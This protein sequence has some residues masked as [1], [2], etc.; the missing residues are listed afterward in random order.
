M[1]WGGGGGEVGIG[2]ERGGVRRGRG[3]GDHPDTAF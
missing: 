2:G 3:S 1:R